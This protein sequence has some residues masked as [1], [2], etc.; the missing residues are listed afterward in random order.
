[1]KFLASAILG[2]MLVLYLTRK[3]RGAS[4]SEPAE[5]LAPENP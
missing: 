2:A 5:S 4:A 1:L 3:P